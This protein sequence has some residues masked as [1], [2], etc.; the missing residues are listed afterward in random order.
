MENITSVSAHLNL[1]NQTL[2]IL[3]VK[4]SPSKQRPIFSSNKNT[5]LLQTALATAT[6]ISGKLHSETLLLFDSGSQRTYISTE[7]REKL[8][9]PTVTQERILI[10]TFGQSDFSA[11]AVDIVV[12]K[13]K[14][15]NTERFVEAI[16]MSVIC[17]EL[18]N[19]NI[20]F[21][22]QNY[23]HLNGLELAHC[24]KNSVKKVDMLVGLDYT[25]HLLL[26]KV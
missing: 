8:E 18:L 5:V 1:R 11:P 7:L 25:A 19:Q 20:A 12:V 17:S 2:L 22:S 21:A 23:A 3:P 14:K 24:S 26:A 10:K 16:C 13:I 9:L 6:N 4:K 15:G